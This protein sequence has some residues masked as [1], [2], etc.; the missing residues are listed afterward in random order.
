MTLGRA[1]QLVDQRLCRLMLQRVGFSSFGK[2]LK[3]LWRFRSSPTQNS[4]AHCFLIGFAAVPP[5]SVQEHGPSATA[6]SATSMHSTITR[7]SHRRFSH[8]QSPPSNPSPSNE[9]CP[10]G[11]VA[12]S[13]TSQLYKLVN[14][15]SYAV[16]V[17]S[18]AGRPEILDPA[19][20]ECSIILQSNT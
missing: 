17:M 9:H 20:L 6:T 19:I 16:C 12:L 13:S 8:A 3:T 4:A 5:L 18:T 7:F 2:I 10:T 11:Q 15:W 14:Q 1:G